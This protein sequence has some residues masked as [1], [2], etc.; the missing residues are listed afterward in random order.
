M[1]SQ[2]SLRCAVI[3]NP[4]AHSRS[5]EIHRAFAQQFKLNVAYERMLADDNDFADHVRGFFAQGGKGLNITVPF[6]EKAFALAQQLHPHA[7]LAGA[8]NT[9]WMQDGQLHGA[10]TDGSGLVHD[11]KRLG[12]SPENKRILLIGAGGAAKGVILPLLDTNASHIRIINRT[13]DKAH[14]LVNQVIEHQAQMGSKLT[15]GG[16][17]DTDGTWD[18]VINATSSGLEQKSPLVQPLNFSESSLAYDMLYSTQPT[19]FMQECAQYGA[20]QQADGLGMLV[21]QAA[22]SFDIWHQQQPDVDAVLQVL[23]RQIIS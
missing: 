4:I 18:I 8:V 11:L 17:T 19:A 7:Q 13:A 12:F 15:A 20:S 3:G 6:K 23:R 21:A 22:H 2:L 1:S 10:N 5:P 14:A 9:L 16:L